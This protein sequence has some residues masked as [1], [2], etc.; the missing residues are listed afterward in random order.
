[1]L[2]FGATTVNVTA[3][4]VLSVEPL[5]VNDVAPSMASAEIYKPVDPSVAESILVE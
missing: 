5:I 4:S 3:D 2:P 1:M